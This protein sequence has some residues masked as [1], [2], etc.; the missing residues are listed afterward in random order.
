MLVV[1]KGARLFQAGWAPRAVARS[2]SFAA[3]PLGEI[4]SRV[5]ASGVGNYFANLALFPGRVEFHAFFP[6]NTQ[7]VAVQPIGDGGLLLL[8]T[9]TQRGFSAADQSWFALIAQKLDNSLERWT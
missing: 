4:C 1:Y 7:G 3:P 6:D 5:A 8:G 2:G 9:G